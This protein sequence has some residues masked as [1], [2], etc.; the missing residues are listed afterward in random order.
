MTDLRPSI[1]TAVFGSGGDEPYLRALRESHAVVQLRA[2]GTAAEDVIHLPLSR[3]L[4][5]ASRSEHRLVAEVPGPVLDI[6][7]GPGRM[8][9]AAMRAGHRSLGVDVS[10][11]AVQLAA[12]RGAP[13]TQRSVFESLP[14]EG[15]W[16][17]ALLLDGNVGIGGDPSALLRR[18]AELV[19]ARGWIVVEA[20]H[21]ETRD[22][23]IDG[24]LVDAAG[25][26]S[27]SFPWAEVG[28]RALDRHAAG[29]GLGLVRRW[30]LPAG[31]TI[32]A[33]A[34]RD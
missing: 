3:Y 32:V 18:C 5:D 1:S 13:V 29:A 28:T 22:V 33:Y 34:S 15:R 10:A 17:S 11:A 27:A 20:H 7:C 30:R 25:G 16:G 31:R 14:S 19:H 24:E 12:R 2:R 26:I 8:V 9:A 23:T 21:D 6:G 4:G